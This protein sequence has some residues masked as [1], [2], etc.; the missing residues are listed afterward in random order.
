VYRSNGDGTPKHAFNTMIQ[1][2][3]TGRMCIA[4][5]SLIRGLDISEKVFEFAEKKNIYTSI[6]KTTKMI[7]LPTVRK[8]LIDD[9]YNM[10][11]MYE[12]VK[13]VENEF[14]ELNGMIPSPQLI[15]KI[16]VCKSYMCTFVPEYIHRVV[17]RIGTFMFFSD[18]TN[19]QETFI[20][21]YSLKVVEG[22]SNIL[23][24][25]LVK[26]VLV[27]IM[28]FKSFVFLLFKLCTILLQSQKNRDYAFLQIKFYI[29]GLKL[30]KDHDWMGRL[31][32][33]EELS[34]Q[35]CEWKIR[36]LC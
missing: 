3:L 30:L 26:D 33:I 18:N 14:H 7:D 32:E 6:G 13:K 35:Y 31:N 4:T 29:L 17:D 15:E 27:R 24:Q 34:K 1:R 10:Y 19:L 8:L 11:R 16:N 21:L 22:D 12:Y 9:R 20:T 2:L 36:Y 23:R 28:N 25:K 5:A